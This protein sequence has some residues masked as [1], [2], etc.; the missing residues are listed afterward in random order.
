[1]ESIKHS[2]LGNKNIKTS[3]F[4]I[5]DNDAIMCGYCCILFIEYMLNN[6]RLSDSTNLFSSWNF[7]KNDGMIKKYFP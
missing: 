2:Y 4:R 6:K 1:M 5:Q 3:I 7:K